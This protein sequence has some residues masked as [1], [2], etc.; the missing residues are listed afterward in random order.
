MQAAGE[1]QA[2]AQAANGPAN[3]DTVKVDAVKA[4]TVKLHSTMAALRP[5]M[6]EAAAKEAEAILTRMFERAKR[7]GQR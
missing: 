3:A 5:H 1:N 7:W 4:D 6:T 2:S